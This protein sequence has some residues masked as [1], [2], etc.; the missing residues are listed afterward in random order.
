M[1]ESTITKTV[2]F[3]ATP[4]F[5]WPFLIEK[6]K[7]ATWFHPPREDLS[8]GEDY[9]LVETDADGAQNPVCWGTVLKMTPPTTLEYTFT[10][11]P[12]GGVMTKVRWTL[13]DCHGGTRLTMVH[14]GVGAAGD[15][16]LGMLTALDNGWD[17]HFAGLREAVR[18]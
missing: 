9:A 1:T 8:E 4:A 7:L 2:F 3:A 5:V 18:G 17:Q 6:D 13:E 16:A 10:V 11:K 12:L 15:V 14:E